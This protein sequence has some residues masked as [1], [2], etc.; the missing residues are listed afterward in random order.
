MSFFEDM[1]SSSR[2]AGFM[3]TLLAL[4]VLVGFGSLYMFVFDEGLQGGSKSIQT[5]IKEQDELLKSLQSRLEYSTQTLDQSATRTS[6]AEELTRTVRQMELREN[7]K[8]D[9]IASIST[10]KNAADDELEKWEEYKKQYRIAERKRAEKELIGNLTTKSG[11]KYQAAVIKKVEDARISFSHSDGN[12]TMLFDDIP[13]AMIDRFQMTKQAAEKSLGGER[14]GNDLADLDKAIYELKEEIAFQNNQIRESTQIY[15]SKQNDAAGVT[16]RIASYESE[17]NSLQQRIAAQAN[18]EGLKNTNQLR[19][20][21]ESL[22]SKIANESAK[23][24][25][26]SAIQTNYSDMKIKKETDIRAMETKIRELENRR[27]KMIQELKA[28]AEATPPK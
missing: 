4:V 15:Q 14:A 9:L 19:S 2:G 18:K 12:N 17:I 7:H 21:I 20:Q 28:K 16:S 26:F 10:L 25:N 8:T 6:V 11:K 3:G 23:R 1:F 13:D 5:V 27:L 22:Q 24:T